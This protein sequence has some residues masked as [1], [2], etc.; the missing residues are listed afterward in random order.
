MPE[1]YAAADALL[2]SLKKKDIFALTVPTK[3]QSY[4]NAGKPII[5]S[6]DGEGARIIA[7]S[8]AGI[9]CPAEDA[10]GLAIAIHKIM[11]MPA[12]GRKKMG[13]NGR[14]YFLENH[15]IRRQVAKLLDIFSSLS[16]TAA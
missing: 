11:K 4:L 2:V 16:R 13:K 9:I 7:E 12:A 14:R 1:L 3:I 8:G 5:G 6:L 10:A 15:E